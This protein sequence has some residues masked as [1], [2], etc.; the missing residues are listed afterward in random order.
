MFR[1]LEA[2]EPFVDREFRPVSVNDRPAG[3]PASLLRS[4]T[5]CVLNEPLKP[6][7]YI[8]AHPHVCAR[9]T[10]SLM[11]RTR[12]RPI[13]LG[14]V[15]HN[16]QRLLSATFRNKLGGE[17]LNYMGDSDEIQIEDEKFYFCFFLF[18]GLDMRFVI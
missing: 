17:Y 12:H 6:P 16:G 4:L 9:P 11:R 10:F 5:A 14:V 3:F 7:F 2:D 1:G 15:V 13:Y 18:L 8:A